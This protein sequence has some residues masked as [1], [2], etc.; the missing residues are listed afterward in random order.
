MAGAKNMEQDINPSCSK[1]VEF[2]RIERW[3][4]EHPDFT[5]DYFS[6]KATRSM[7]DAWVLSHAL[8]Q[9]Y[10][11]PGSGGLPLGPLNNPMADTASTGSGSR[12]SSGANTPV[13]KISAQEFERGG[14]ILKPMLSTVD[15]TPTFLGAPNRL[16]LSAPRNPR[17]SR[18]ELKALDERELMYELV[19]DICHDLDVT[20]LCH[21]ILQNVAVMLNAD[22][23]SIF[24]VHGE[25][26]SE[27]RCL[28]SKLFDVNMHSTLQDCMERGEEIRVAWDTGIIGYVANVGHKV[29]IADAYE[30]SKHSQQDPQQTQNIFI[31]F[32]QC[33]TNVEDVG[34]TLYKCYKNVLYLLRHSQ[35]KHV[36]GSFLYSIQKNVP[37]IHMVH[38]GYV[39]GIFL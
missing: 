9:S 31:T 10:G 8:S 7:V 1:E 36:E 20:S 34:A 16:E 39:C 32:V 23:C 37:N 29:N 25:E 21:K 13:R 28:V 19:M 2:D 22:R 17:K 4:D 3:L 14:Q 35:K 11:S 6:R 30:V 24:L 27:N 5:H 33:W 26:N 18:S 15:G 12:T 38:N